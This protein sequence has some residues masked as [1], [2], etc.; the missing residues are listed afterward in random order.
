[1]SWR[2]PN[3]ARDWSSYVVLTSMVLTS[4]V[5]CARAPLSPPAK[6]EELT[7]GESEWAGNEWLNETAQQAAKA[8]A[9]RLHTLAV[10]AGAPGDHVPALVNVPPDRCALLYARGSDSIED[11]DL[12]VYGDDGA[13][14]GS[15]EAIDPRPTLL[16]CVESG[17]R[18]YVTARVAAGHGLVALGAQEVARRDAEAVAKAAGARNFGLSEGTRPEVWP[19]LQ[20]ALGIHRR[21][22]G[23]SWEDVRRVALPI[24]FRVPTRISSS[25]AA[26]TCLDALA[27][28]A[29]EGTQLELEVLDETGRILGRSHGGG[30]RSL[31]VCSE[32]NARVTYQLRSQQGHGLAVLALSSTGREGLLDLD[33]DVPRSFVIPKRVTK[34]QP[35][36]SSSGD[37]VRVGGRTST[38]VPWSGGCGRIDVRSDGDLLGLETLLWSPEDRLLASGEGLTTT[39]LFVCA[40]RSQLRLDV[41]ATRRQGGFSLDV[42]QAAVAPAPLLSHPLAA[43]RLLGRLYASGDLERPEQVGQIEAA[44]LTPTQL[45]RLEFLVPVQRCLDVFLGL[46]EGGAGAELR[47]TD[48]ATGR[49][50]QLAR[51]PSGAKA[52]ACALGSTSLRLRAELRVSTGSATGL[53]ATRLRSGNPP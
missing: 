36:K 45:H 15:D 42:Q 39:T 1:M 37:L 31:L 32:E 46:G 24:D 2:I 43:S 20:E 19:G 11:L 12:F 6:A 30:A 13:Q 38:E 17:H 53:V 27:L 10:G 47:L 8:G 52:G 35:S 40:P 26:G 48:A 51:G 34:K 4:M 49:E 50:I 5:A 28:S 33:P 41:E 23:G 22:L 44:P 3:A 9:G 25:L 16:I 7:P 29:E 18:L 14:F 21:H